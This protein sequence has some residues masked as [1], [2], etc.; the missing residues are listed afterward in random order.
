MNATP[1]F[2]GNMWQLGYTIGWIFSCFS[3]QP[4]KLTV[5]SHYIFKCVFVD[6]IYFI[7]VFVLILQMILVQMWCRTRSNGFAGVGPR[8]HSCIRDQG[9]R[10]YSLYDYKL[11]QV[12]HRCLV[13]TTLI[14]YHKLGQSTGH[15]ISIYTNFGTAKYIKNML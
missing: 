11:P 9:S 5:M 10:I 6:N 8:S 4:D 15:C 7:L 13:Q 12:H 2:P 3:P 14:V 1:L